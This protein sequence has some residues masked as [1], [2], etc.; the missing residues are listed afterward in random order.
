MR[1]STRQTSGSD[2]AGNGIAAVSN[3]KLKLSS[4]AVAQ[5]SVPTT[6][7]L[8]VARKTGSIVTRSTA[9]SKTTGLQ[10]PQEE[11]SSSENSAG[12]VVT[13]TLQRRFPRASN[14]A[15][16]AASVSAAV[17]PASGE[18][19][20]T[21]QGQDG[22]L[23]SPPP[24]VLTKLVND[25][26]T[27]GEM[28]PESLKRNAAAEAPINEN[29]K[30]KKLLVLA[31]KPQL[32]GQGIHDELVAGSNANGS[33]SSEGGRSSGAVSTTTELSAEP[34]RGVT[35]AGHRLLLVP[36]SNG[37]CP[38]PGRGGG[39][40]PAIATLSTSSRPGSDP[41][42]HRQN[43]TSAT[44]S[45][46]SP[47][48]STANR[49]NSL[50]HVVFLVEEGDTPASSDSVGVSI[51]S[52]PVQTR[53]QCDVPRAVAPREFNGV[54]VAP[55]IN[56]RRTTAGCN[57]TLVAVPAVPTKT[58]TS[59]HD[60]GKPLN[61]LGMHEMGTA[62]SQ[63]VSTFSGT[64][65]ANADHRARGTK[66]SEQRQQPQVLQQ[67]VLQEQV[68]KQQVPH[69]QVPQ[70]QPPQLQQQL[71][72]P[73]EC[74]SLPKPAPV[75]SQSQTWQQQLSASVGLSSIVHIVPAA[76]ATFD[77]AA[78][79]MPS[80]LHPY[81]MINAATLGMSDV[82]RQLGQTVSDEVINLISDDEDSDCLEV[83]DG[84]PSSV[85]RHGYTANYPVATAVNGMV[86]TV[87]AGSPLL[88]ASPV[89]TTSDCTNSLVLSSLIQPVGAGS[90]GSVFLVPTSLAVFPGSIY[91][92]SMPSLLP[93]TM[94]ESAS[95]APS[96][97]QLQATTLEG[98]GGMLL[99][100]PVQP[101]VSA[102]T[103][104][105]QLPLP[106]QPIV[107]HVVNSAQSPLQPQP[108]SLP[109]P[110]P[111]PPLLPT[112][113]LSPSPLPLLPPV[114]PSTPDLGVDVTSSSSAHDVTD[115]TSGQLVTPAVQPSPESNHCKPPEDIVDTLA[116]DTQFNT[117]P[118]VSK[119]CQEKEA[120]L[121]AVSSPLLTDHDLTEDP[122][123]R[124]TT[125]FGRVLV[126][127][128]S[129]GEDVTVISNRA[130]FG[131]KSNVE[132]SS[133]TRHEEAGLQPC[134]LAPRKVLGVQSYLKRTRLQLQRNAKQPQLSSWSCRTR[135][136]ADDAQDTTCSTPTDCSSSSSRVALVMSKCKFVRTPRGLT[137]PAAPNGS[138]A[139][140]PAKPRKSNPLCLCKWKPTKATESQVPVYCQALD[141]V[142]GTPTGCIKHAVMDCVGRS[143]WKIPIM[144]LCKDHLQRLRSHECCPG[145]GLFCI[146]GQFVQCRSDTLYVHLFH[147]S[148]Q[149]TKSG[150]AH[151]PHCG[152]ESLE[153]KVYLRRPLHLARTQLLQP[154]GDVTSSESATAVLKAVRLKAARPIVFRNMSKYTTAVT[155]APRLAPTAV[156]AVLTNRQLLSTTGLEA[157]D[158]KQ[159][160]DLAKVLEKLRTTG[161]K[162]LR[163]SAG[164][165]LGTVYQVVRS[166]SIVKLVCMLADD[167]DPNARI[168]EAADG[169]PLHIA[170][171]HGHLVIV[172]CLLQVGAMPNMIDKNES[173]PLMLA[174]SGN[175]LPVVKYLIRA[176]AKVNM[177]D[178]E[179]QTALHAAAKA[180]CL[181][182]VQ[183]LVSTTEIDINIQDL[184]GWT[185]LA[186]STENLHTEV[187]KYLLCTGSDPSLR[188][189]ERN[190]CLHWAVYSG[191]TELCVA[192]LDAGCPVEAVN[193]NGDRALHIAA[194]RGHYAIVAMLLAR[195]ADS[196]A[197][198]NMNQ[199]PH[200]C[201]AVEKIQKV[202][203]VN[204][205]LRSFKTC[206]VKFTETLLHC[207]ISRGR[208][209]IPISCVN[210]VDDM[211][212]PEDYVYVTANVES[213]N[214][215]IDRAIASIQRCSCTG[216]CS[217]MSCGCAKAG[218]RCWY[219]EH[220][221]LLP[222]IS[223]SESPMIFECNQGCHCWMNCR[224]RVVQ[225]GTRCRLQL[226]RTEKL[227]WG[228]R[229]LKDIPRGTF[230]CEYTGEII[231]DLEAD[232]RQHDSYLFDLD[233]KDGET[234]C[235]DG[236]SYGNIGRFI[237]HH[238]DPNIAP[239]RVLVEHRDVRFPRICFFAVRDIIASEELGFDYGDDFWFI[240]YKN[241][242]CECGSSHCKFSRATIAQTMAEHGRKLDEKLLDVI[243]SG[244]P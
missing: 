87:P 4:P 179:G 122:Q 182:T 130:R 110:S 58:S 7:D 193:A 173:T 101:A 12:V 6:G 31:P 75:P 211:N 40:S 187:A 160:V 105:C 124:Q 26:L 54:T 141:C 63:A 70:Q 222:D 127:E 221:R 133:A 42:R 114:Q 148:C 71:M 223:L 167:I 83:T 191:S 175:H 206:E 1:P 47:Q 38:P 67:Q 99:P 37:C 53:N 224:N 41:T 235:I 15:T 84:L 205:Q 152:A 89:T 244:S 209:P 196:K 21:D 107:S 131:T 237:N 109:P 118:V 180:G 204:Q 22:Y 164:G 66:M 200:Q 232:R 149:V 36:V 220:G 216:N 94:S 236:F 11:G 93:V 48:A 82:S 117:N 46:P 98:A 81:A 190:T 214:L 128:V 97:Q 194:R 233:S 181:A 9:I 113:L 155:E 23:Q 202:L 51:A 2:R 169:T 17:M 218:G 174:C 62:T 74:D 225:L 238:C 150:K 210:S 229:T 120:D 112:P 86:S 147:Q 171:E 213:A 132:V 91:S 30:R 39:S 226:F 219:D 177:K 49:D 121:L 186:W 18:S 14:T 52:V 125:E 239:V 65:P 80:Q 234:Y 104:S 183:F 145:C 55:T 165:S 159:I 57:T 137:L 168:P 32:A 139:T 25:T 64:K 119:P 140:V 215:G 77:V 126:D 50:L 189:Q 231:S 197:V 44:A 76:G 34:G 88:A 217:A 203:T 199:L 172:H 60:V 230:I 28:R 19:S 138:R 20:V 154:A 129:N 208:E 201:T 13:A 108:P 142:D 176:G 78:T 35:V 162:E 16:V 24:N 27:L 144:A 166:N 151:C 178:N 136:A 153:T 96:P 212:F 73:S 43:L 135:S 188:D 242:T 184:G 163:K 227:G 68:P 95:P 5:S 195:G 92:L 143:G 207:D 192:Y 170:S 158:A 100:L 106:T 134:G 111:P 240:K 10:K 116:A 146:S 90:V 3:D 185:A 228:V 243:P 85:S 79:E 115:I 161:H 8:N 123:V 72:S 69:Q 102:S 33:H 156:S 29:P 45:I 241:F 103:E 157:A 61:Q 59:A 198:N 56:G